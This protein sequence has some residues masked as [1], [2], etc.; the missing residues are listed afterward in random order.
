[1]HSVPQCPT[2]LHSFFLPF[3]LLAAPPILKCLPA[4][5]IAGLLAAPVEASR[6]EVIVDR[7]L[8]VEEILQEMGPIRSLDEMN[9][10]IAV[11]VDDAIQYLSRLRGGWQS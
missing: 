8:T 4:P 6:V 7:P 2:F 10:E 9:A 11:I 5:R 1:M 3:P